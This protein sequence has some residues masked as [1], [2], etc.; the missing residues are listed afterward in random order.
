MMKFI[1]CTTALVCVA[2]AVSACGGSVSVAPPA[3]PPPNPLYVSFFSG[4]DTNLGD[5]THPLKSVSRATQLALSGYQIFVGPGTYGGG[6]TTV[7]TGTA[8]QGLQIIAD[9]SGAQ[10]GDQGHAGP[11]VIDAQ[12][13]SVGFQLNKSPGSLIDGFT[14]INTTDA[15]IVLKS[16]SHDFTIQNCIVHDNTGDGI[17]VQDSASVVVFNNLVYRNGGDG[18]GIVGST[19]GS[20]DAQVFSNTVYDNGGHGLTVG[21]TAKA[22]AGACVC[23]NIVENNDATT[24]SENIKVITNPRS[25]LNYNHCGCNCNLVFPAT[26][27]PSAIQGSD[28]F[29]GDAKFVNPPGDLHLQASSP[30]IDPAASSACALENH[31]TTSQVSILN[32]RTTTGTNAHPGPAE[33][34]ALDLGFHFLRN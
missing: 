4:S 11:V 23:H 12:Q 26:Y 8:Q 3:E 9:P 28:D 33:S 16:G 20:P 24:P 34:G 1:R 32:Q 30:A 17:R 18:I 29:N 5:Q 7:S 19:S 25:D 22:S 6:V 13:Q 15:A 31:L 10:T 27:N 21:T 14:I 2:A